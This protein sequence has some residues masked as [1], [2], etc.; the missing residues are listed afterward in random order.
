MFF[1]LHEA[2]VRYCFVILAAFSNS[3]VLFS[4]KM[5]RILHCTEW[6]VLHK[7][8]TLFLI[9]PLIQFLITTTF[10]KYLGMFERKLDEVIVMRSFKEQFPIVICCNKSKTWNSIFNPFSY[11]FLNNL[12]CFEFQNKWIYWII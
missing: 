4:I 12:R 5:L 2:Y 6:R 1:R 11:A 3:S 8:I 9:T 7:R 10:L